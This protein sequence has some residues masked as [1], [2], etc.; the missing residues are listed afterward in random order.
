MKKILLSMMLLASF[1]AMAFKA[2]MTKAQAINEVKALKATGTSLE[3]IIA[4]ATLANV[5]LVLLNEALA[6]A[7][8]TSKAVVEAAVALSIDPAAL[9]PAPAAGNNVLPFAKFNA[10]PASTVSGGGRSS[11]SPS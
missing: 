4:A 1:S 7:G 8:Y 6:A 11:V 2:D 9:V 5:D 10:S 3:S